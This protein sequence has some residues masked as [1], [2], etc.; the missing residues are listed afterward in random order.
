[1]SH[2][3]RVVIR[4]LSITA[5]LGTA[6]TFTVVSP[7]PSPWALNY[8]DTMPVASGRVVRFAASYGL[9]GPS[10]ALVWRQ[11]ASGAVSG[12][13]LVWYR[14]FVPAD[15]GR[16]P[17]ADSAA[18]WRRM[19]TAMAS[20]R[21]RLDSLY[22][23]ESW[24][25]GFQDGPAWVCR[26]SEQKGTVN[27]TRELRSLDSL[28]AARGKAGPPGGRRY[29]PDTTRADRAAPPGVTRVPTGGVAGCMDGGSWA[30]QV[31]DSLGTRTI[32]APPSSGCPRPAGAA[33]TYDEAGWRM[34]REFIAAVK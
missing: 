20:E 29:A 7:Q 9:S 10:P 25:R 17:A 32:T 33:R 22:G 34:L 26:V 2:P 1:M 14:A 24:A 3:N 6:C 8:P 5:T 27:W 23:C 31:K 15:A 18:E 11:Q 19:Q 21:T 28:V 16:R 13:M 4:A 30:I 12:Q